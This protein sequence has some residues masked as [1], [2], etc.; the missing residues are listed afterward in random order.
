MHGHDGIGGVRLP[1]GPPAA[2]GIAADAIREMLHARP[3]PDEITLVGIG[4]A[5]NLALVLATEP[6]L[7][8]RVGEIVLMTGAWSEGNATPAAEFNA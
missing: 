5:T 6:V 4:P 3:R 1:D 7:A 2:P 8:E